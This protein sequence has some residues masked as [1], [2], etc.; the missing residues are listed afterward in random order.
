MSGSKMAK[1][2]ATGS[3]MVARIALAIHEV[4][5]ERMVPHDG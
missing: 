1:R 4:F 5:A 3:V 2:A